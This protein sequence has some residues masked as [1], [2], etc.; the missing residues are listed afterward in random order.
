VRLAAALLESARAEA[1][2]AETRQQRQTALLARN[3]TSMQ[4]FD[5]AELAHDVAV[6]RTREAE[7]HL[8]V[9]QRRLEKARL[10]APFD[11]IIEARLVEPHELTTRHSKVVV[12]TDL[13][14]VKV[15][16]ALPDR[17]IARL[18]PGAEAV[19]RAAAWPGREFRGQVT[20]I[21]VSVDPQTRTVPFEVTLDNA[22]LALRPQLGVEVELS[23]TQNGARTSLPLAAV[24]RDS[25]RE[26]FCFVVD[27]SEGELQAE[28]RPLVLGEIAQDRVVVTAG[29]T[30]GETVVV[31]G[32]HFVHAG[33][34]LNVVTILED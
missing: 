34:P 12:L 26:P 18:A 8:S 14:T 9:A 3:S 32:Q 25:E 13:R 11:G 29:L 6:S 2:G 4:H 33:D 10:R 16:A 15:Q 20:R 22:D 1:R 23:L 21:D 31:R 7:L 28:R 30:P 5:Q 27:E 24:L 17:M 19:V